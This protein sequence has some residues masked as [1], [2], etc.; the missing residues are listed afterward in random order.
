MSSLSTSPSTSAVC[1]PP[2]LPAGWCLERMDIASVPEVMDIEARA[3]PFPWT[4]RNFED[5]VHSGYVG[6]LLRDD[7]RCLI[8]YAVVMPVVDEMH[9][10]NLTIAPEYQRRGLGAWLL[11]A[12]SDAAR[13]SGYHGLLLEVRPTNDAAIALYQHSGFAEIGRR[14]AYYPAAD[15]AR[16][17][18]LV[19]RLAW[20]MCEDNTTAAVHG[21]FSV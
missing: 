14:R 11:Q 7:T 2:G 9:L 12:V 21:G 18:A 3:Y 6:L 19:M 8:G 16:E 4:P 10:L 13:V 17:D 20:P 1:L 5:S 15:G